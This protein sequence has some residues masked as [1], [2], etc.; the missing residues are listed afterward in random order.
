MT[1][2]TNTG[3]GVAPSSLV[4]APNRAVKRVTG[5]NFTPAMSKLYNQL[6]K[7]EADGFIL[8]L[9]RSPF[10]ENK[11]KSHIYRGTFSDPGE[12][13]CPLGYNRGKDGYSIWRNNIGLGICRRC[14]LN[15]TRLTTKV[16]ETTNDN[17]AP[18]PTEGIINT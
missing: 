14:L 16:G 6:F 4:T 5:N 11:H 8:G 9:E 12:P 3:D 15:A 10:S 1:S 2:H 7:M 18:S 13:L 17:G